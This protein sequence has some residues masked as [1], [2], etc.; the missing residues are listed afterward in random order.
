MQFAQLPLPALLASALYVH[1][2]ATVAACRTDIEAIVI[3]SDEE[4]LERACAA[5]LGHA[6]ESASYGPNEALRAAWTHYPRR[7]GIRF[8]Y[9]PIDLPAAGPFAGPIAPI[10]S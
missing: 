6:S 5:G 9:L 4:A 10:E 1:T 3:S 2:L 7:Q 8:A